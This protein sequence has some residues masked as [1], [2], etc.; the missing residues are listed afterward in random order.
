[1]ENLLKKS[2][3]FKSDIWALGCT[4]YEIVYG[5]YLFNSQKDESEPMAINAILDFLNMKNSS[6]FNPKLAYKKA[7]GKFSLEYG[8]INNFIFLTKS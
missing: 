2:W 4:I 7:N 5:T 6:D 1:M 8:E 3:D